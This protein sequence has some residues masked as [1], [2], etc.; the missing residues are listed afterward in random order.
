MFCP[1]PAV[2]REFIV[3]SR[4]MQ[5]C[6][7]QMAMTSTK[8][9]ERSANSKAQ[10]AGASLSRL[11]HR[12]RHSSG[13]PNNLEV[14]ASSVCGAQLRGVFEHLGVTPQFL[15][16]WMYCAIATSAATSVACGIHCRRPACPSVPWGSRGA[17]ERLLWRL[18]PRGN[19][20]SAL[21]AAETAVLQSALPM[22][23]D[24]ADRAPTGAVL[25][26]PQ[27]AT[28]PI[29]DSILPKCSACTGGD[30]V[31]GGCTAQGVER[32]P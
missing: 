16:C 6:A 21:P 20:D 23:G 27:A 1:G 4:N 26:G 5:P 29:G 25:N 31:G 28:D 11:L 3:W 9:C 15:S 7:K 18:A 32:N 2:A 19:C 13:M 24:C 30:E 8:H 14:I 10:N 12:D 22:Q 17:A